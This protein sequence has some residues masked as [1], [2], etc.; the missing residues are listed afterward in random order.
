MRTRIFRVACVLA[1]L[2]VLLGALAA[3]GDQGGT[4]AP[5]AVDNVTFK[6]PDAGGSPGKSVT[7][8]A[9]GDRKIFAEAK[10][11]QT[12]TNFSGKAVWTAVDTSAGKGITVAEAPLS[13]LA[14]NILTTNAELPRDWPTGT[15]RVSFYQGDTLL[16]AQE[17]TIR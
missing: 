1:F 7:A 4:P 11:N 14:G 13:G 5:L 17:F 8:F 16:K 6:L 15:Y 3:C 2:P 10:L 12:V 9:P